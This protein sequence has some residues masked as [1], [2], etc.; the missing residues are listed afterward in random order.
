MR[1]ISAF[2]ALLAVLLFPAIAA[3][4][5]I[6]LVNSRLI[7]GTGAPPRQNQTV[8]VEDG[9]IAAVFESGSRSLAAGTKVFD[10]AGSALLPG[11]IDGH[12]HATDAKNREAQL[13]ALLESGV[14]TV[15][16]LAGDARITGDLAR[17]AARGEIASPAIYYPAVIFGPGFFEDDRA[18]SSAEGK[19][20][21]SSPWSRVVTADSDIARIVSEARQTGATG[22]KLYASLTPDLVRQLTQ[23]AHRQGLLVWAHTV[24]FPAG[25]EHAVE[26]GAD[27]VIHAKGM[28][29]LGRDDV[30]GTFK[31]GTQVWVRQFDYAGSD[32]GSPPFQELYAEMARRGTI[33]EP[34]LMADGE[35]RPKPL[36]QWLAALR[37]WSCRATRAA[38]K[39]GVTIGAGTDSRLIAGQIQSELKRLV[40]CGLTPLEA[41]RAATFNNARAIGIGDTHGT[42]EVGKA[43]DLIAVAGDPAADIRATNDVRLVMQAGRLVVSPD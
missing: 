32:P 34:A 5:S 26:A 3:A 2:L 20:P 25:V 13:R 36:P 38:H 21:G 17:R 18:Q 1:L 28:I 10:L 22:L 31:E 4:E 11:L 33:L 7:D 29:S 8:L 16:D 30:P 39:A 43:A 23:E 9:R 35:R 37:D 15:R 14:T 19:A 40:D 6:A 24:I 42:I 12:V 27:S 41:I